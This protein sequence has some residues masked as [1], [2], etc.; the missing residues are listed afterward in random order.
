MFIKSIKRLRT[1]LKKSK[2]HQAIA[3]VFKKTMTPHSN[4]ADFPK[5]TENVFF[6]ISSFASLI[7]LGSWGLVLRVCG[8]FWGVSC[9]P[10]GLC[11][12]CLGSVLVALGVLLALWGVSCWLFGLCLGYLGS[13]LVALGLFLGALGFVLGATL[14]S[15][16]SSGA[17]CGS[18]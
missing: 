10:F 3:S 8:T 14:S 17:F 9:W 1:S 2:K 5:K 7:V 15:W 12:G 6:Q 13:V 18:V 16:V 4:L 11:L